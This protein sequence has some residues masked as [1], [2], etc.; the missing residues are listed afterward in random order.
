MNGDKASIDQ[1]CAFLKEG[2]LDERVDIV[3][4]VPS[5]YLD[6]VKQRFP[7]G[8]LAAA[9][10][11]YKVPKGAFT[12]EISPAMLKDI[13]IEWVILGHSERRSIFGETDELVAEKCAHALESGLKVIVCCGESLEERES[14][15][16]E[17][18]VVRQLT[19][20]AKKIKDWGKVVIA[21]EPVWAIG[22]GKTATPAQAQETHAQIRNWMKEKVCPDVA[23][24]TRVLYGGSVNADNCKELGKQH[25]IDGFL[26]GGASLKPDFVKI[27]NATK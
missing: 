11:C 2:P 10:N 18:V 24:A 12:G 4:G 22:T 23:E 9:E 7:P 19:A 8:V 14:N 13:G 17:E 27:I 5:V 16:T 21:Y 1:I 15:R 26:V 6:Y 3:I 25:D 20:C